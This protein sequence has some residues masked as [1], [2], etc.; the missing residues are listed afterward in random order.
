MVPPSPSISESDDA[1]HLPK[2]PLGRMTY[3]FFCLKLGTFH[4]M[5]T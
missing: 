5:G 3:F 4:I 1:P 2:K